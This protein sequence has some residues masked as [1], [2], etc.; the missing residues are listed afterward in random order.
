MELRL[1]LSK[2]IIAAA[3]LLG[4]CSQPAEVSSQG[5]AFPDRRTSF[6]NEGRLLGF[7]SNRLSDSV[8]VLDLDDMTELGRVPIGR[9]P[10]DVDGP[11]HLVVD[12]E[13]ALVYVALSHPAPAVQGPH[14][15]HVAPSLPGYVELRT[16]RALVT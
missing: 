11:T 10:V 2:T 3:L 14:A 8:S 4:G 9:S 16:Q 6:E 1:R 12:R 13:R 5:D 7:V 15:S